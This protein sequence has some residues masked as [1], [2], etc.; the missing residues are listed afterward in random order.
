MEAAIP[1]LLDECHPRTSAHRATSEYRREM[2][3]VLL[4]Q[5][6]GMAIHRAQ[7]Q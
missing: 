3:S 6:W 7:G 4:K 1:V 2:L 5:T